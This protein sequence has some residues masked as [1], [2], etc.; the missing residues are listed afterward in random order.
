[1]SIPDT[2]EQRSR[3]LGG[4]AQLNVSSVITS[5]ILA[6]IKSVGLRF[7]ILAEKSVAELAP[8]TESRSGFIGVVAIEPVVA[9]LTPFS[10]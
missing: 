10:S 1:M 3:V 5:V 6:S 9:S 7:C 4:N 8:K 2:L